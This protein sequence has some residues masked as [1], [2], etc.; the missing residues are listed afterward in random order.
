MLNGQESARAQGARGKEIKEADHAEGENGEL[1][2][3]GKDLPGLKWKI[4]PFKDR[5]A[6]SPFELHN[7]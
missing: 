6:F 3:L 4:Q 1:G 7:I 5:S 2:V